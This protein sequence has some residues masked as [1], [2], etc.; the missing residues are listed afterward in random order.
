MKCY[1]ESPQ[2]EVVLQ[3]LDRA[4]CLVIETRTAGLDRRYFGEFCGSAVLAADTPAARPLS[5]GLAFHAAART[6]V[7]VRD[8]INTE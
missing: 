1:R 3:T 7:S 8:A 6:F 5:L 4:E 2:V